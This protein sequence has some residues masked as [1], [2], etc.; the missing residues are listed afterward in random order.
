MIG[1]KLRYAIIGWSF[2]LNP[3]LGIGTFDFT[4]VSIYDPIF[5]DYGRGSEAFLTGLF[6][7]VGL[8]ALLLLATFVAAL[9]RGVRSGQHLHLA[10]GIVLFV[11]MLAYGSFINAYDFVFL[12]MLGL[13]A[14]AGERMWPGRE[15]PARG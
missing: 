1:A 15:A 10:V 7:R 9:A 8:P 14:S 13:L 6:A 3:I 12:A 11:A 2:K 5:G 4:A